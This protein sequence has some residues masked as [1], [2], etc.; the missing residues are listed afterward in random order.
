MPIR[1]GVWAAVIAASTLCWTAPAHAQEPPRLAFRIEEHDLYP[2]SIAYD[3]VSGDF[4][5]GSMGK[6][7][8]LRI[9]PDGSYTDF[10]GPDVPALETSVGLKVDAARR[11]LWVCT[12][13]YVLYGGPQ[14]SAPRTGVLL[15]DLDD[16]ELLQSWLLPQPTPSQIFNDL[17]VA[18]DGGVYVTTTLL[19]RVYHVTA[20][21]DDMALLVDSA[22]MQTNG[23]ALGAE[24][25]YLFFTFDRQIRRLDLTDGSWIDV[26]IPGGAGMGTDG[27]YVHHGSLVAVQPRRRRVVSL[28]L[29]EGQDSVVAERLVAEDHPD[30]AYPTTGVIVGD[31]LFLVAT[32]F[33]DRPRTGGNGPQHPDVLI[34]AWPLAGKER[35]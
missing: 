23:I 31:T 28:P 6:G 2:E 11:R 26:A 27:L 15:F 17:A 7:R 32:S 25:R 22:G 3:S 10:V 18:A 13:R 19:G 8:I 35:E 29:S 24:G 30:F 4:F 21:E 5:L 12:G 16:G 34:Q 1:R 14:T 33:A 9:R 20:G